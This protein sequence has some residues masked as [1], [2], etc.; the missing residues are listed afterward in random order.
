MF[1]SCVCCVSLRSCFCTVNIFQ[2]EQ[3]RS[4]QC[5]EKP[6]EWSNAFC[7]RKLRWRLANTVTIRLR[8]A[9]GNHTVPSMLAFELWSTD[10]M[11]L[12]QRWIQSDSRQWTRFKVSLM[13][14]VRRARHSCFR[15]A[16]D[17]QGCLFWDVPFIYD[18]VA[19]GRVSN[20]KHEVCENG[21]GFEFWLC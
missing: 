12:I 7:N 20:L 16:A 9:S 15:H 21:S 2:K 17:T 6:R 4:P 18:P 10:A 14:T 5:S 13:H 3:Q 11:R 1:T 8:H 19:C